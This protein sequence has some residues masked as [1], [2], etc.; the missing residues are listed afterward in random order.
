MSKKNP[1]TE[2]SLILTSPPNTVNFCV[3]VLTSI[4]KRP[5]PVPIIVK[6]SVP[7]VVWILTLSEECNINPLSAPPA[8]ERTTASASSVL[9]VK[10]SSYAVK[11]P[12]LLA[13]FTSSEILELAVVPPWLFLTFISVMALWLSSIC[14]AALGADDPM[15]IVVVFK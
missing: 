4:P 15:L 3:G 5:P 10:P 14:S 7:D 1:S 2:F 8:A 13:L 9:P 11:V 6:S 12:A